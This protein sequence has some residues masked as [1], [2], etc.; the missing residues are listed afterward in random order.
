M[1]LMQHGHRYYTKQNTK[2]NEESN[3]VDKITTNTKEIK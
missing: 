2:S 3:Q 1:K